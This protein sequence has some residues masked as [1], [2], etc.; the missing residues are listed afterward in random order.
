MPLGKYLTISHYTLHI[1]HYTLHITNY[2]LHITHYKLHITHTVYRGYK[3]NSLLGGRMKYYWYKE[4]TLY[5][6]TLLWILLLTGDIR[7]YIFI[8]NFKGPSWYMRYKDTRIQ[9]TRI[10]GYQ[11]ARIPGYQDI[12]IPG[13]QDTRIPGYQDTRIPGYGTYLSIQRIRFPDVVPCSN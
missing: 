9:D 11:D 12:R 3:L 7:I 1:T 10:P 8:Y 4:N 6:F 5:F 13:Y 2:T